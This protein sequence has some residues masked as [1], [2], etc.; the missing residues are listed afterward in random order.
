MIGSNGYVIAD[1]KPIVA[2]SRCVTTRN[3]PAR[4]EAPSELTTLGRELPFPLDGQVSE[5]LHVSERHG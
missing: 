3:A 5:L 1:A 2:R 4:M